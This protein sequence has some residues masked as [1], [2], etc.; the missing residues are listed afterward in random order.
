MK[1]KE[2]RAMP[3]HERKEIGPGSYAL[4]VPGGW[5][6]EVLEYG[7]LVSST[8]VDD[9]LERAAV[10]IAAGLIGDAVASG[11]LDNM[12]PSETKYAISSPAIALARAVLEAVEEK[13]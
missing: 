7:E 2:L 11:A 4:R 10:E 1:L 12:T 8:R 6:Y 5:I 3:L 13:T 9:P